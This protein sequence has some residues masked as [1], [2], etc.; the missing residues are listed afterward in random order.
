MPKTNSYINY[1]SIRIILYIIVRVHFRKIIK[2]GHNSSMRAEKFV[3]ATR[4]ESIKKQPARSGQEGFAIFAFTAK[5]LICTV[6]S[7]AI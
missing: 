6:N 2:F 7:W 4:I 3:F 1:I 5:L